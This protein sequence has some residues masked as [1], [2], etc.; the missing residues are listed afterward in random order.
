MGGEHGEK[1]GKT[2]GIWVIWGI[3]GMWGQI[4]VIYEA[5]MA[6]RTVAGATQSSRHLGRQGGLVCLD[7]RDL[8]HARRTSRQAEGTP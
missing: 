1:T 6:A 4:W 3:R 5:R 2:W 7:V 8:P